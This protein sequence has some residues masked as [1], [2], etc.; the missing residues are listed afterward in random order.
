MGHGR[1][2]T[3][4]GDGFLAL[5]DGSARAIRTALL[6]REQVAAMGLEVRQAVHEAA[7]ISRRRRTRGQ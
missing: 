4:T 1:E 7:R 5:F 6:I 2:I 3:T